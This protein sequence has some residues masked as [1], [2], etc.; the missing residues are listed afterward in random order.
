MV[1][2]SFAFPFDKSTQVIV[3]M[4]CICPPDIHDL[5]YQLNLCVAVERSWQYMIATVKHQFVN[6]SVW[7]H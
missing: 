1:S 4:V 3:I 7:L 2:P 5:Q 6:R